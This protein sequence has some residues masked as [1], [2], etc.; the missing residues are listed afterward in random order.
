MANWALASD[1]SRA[2]FVDGGRH[3][4]DQVRLDVDAIEIAKMSDDLSHAHLPQSP[5]IASACGRLRHWRPFK[6]QFLVRD[7]LVCQG[8]YRIESYPLREF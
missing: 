7:D 5:Q 2:D 3:R 8:I 6:M 1:H 4:A